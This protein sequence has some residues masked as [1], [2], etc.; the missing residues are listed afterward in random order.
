VIS[1]FCRVV[2]EIRALLG[3]TQRRLVL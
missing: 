2:N 1:G 3:F